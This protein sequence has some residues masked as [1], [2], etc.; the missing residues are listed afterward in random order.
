MATL[1]VTEPGSCL[2][3]EYGRIIITQENEVLDAVPIRK[4]EDV[5]LFGNVG[6]T[7]PALHLLLE[8]G[9]NL[10][11]LSR[12]GK[13]RGIL[14]SYMKP[15]S[16]L[17]PNQYFLTQSESFRIAFSKQIVIGKLSNY[18][19]FLKR[20]L[21]RKLNFQNQLDEE[22]T[23][24]I[25]NSPTL[26]DQIKKKVR[27][28]S[29][30]DELMG[31]EGLGSKTY[32]SVFFKAFSVASGLVINKRQKRPPKDPINAMLSLGYTLLSQSILSAIFISRLD[33]FLGF[34]HANKPGRPALA[35]DLM[36]EFRSV[37]VD[38]LVLTLINKRIIQKHD[39]VQDQNGAIRFGKRGIKVFI[40]QYQ[41]RIDTEIWC[42]REGRKISYRKV[43]ENQARSLSRIIDGSE[44]TY[45]P[46]RWK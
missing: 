20:L 21:R 42:P 32:F 46:H 8:N 19:V 2:E 23:E 5:V 24:R 3:R 37:I 4:L 1:Y 30:I 36:E 11:F 38:S 14:K 25:L 34:F 9:V 35:L 29:S 45:L 16:E 41:K 28:A 44:A 43:F 26:L 40:K 33:P 10:C 7:T 27:K 39:F 17:I 12:N 31:L 15:Q 13:V 18:R 6:V 22:E